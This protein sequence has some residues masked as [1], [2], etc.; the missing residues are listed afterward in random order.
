M[1]GTTV[2]LAVVVACACGPTAVLG[3]YRPVVLMHGLDASASAMSR[4]LQWVE[5][6]FPGIHV[7]NVEVGNGKTDS[8]FM[9]IEKQ[10]EAFAAAVRADPALANGFNLICHSQGGMLGR[11]YIA[12][13]NTPPVHNFITWSSPH[14]GVYGVPDFNAICPDK[15]CPWLNELFSELME[16]GGAILQDH[17]AFAAYWRDPMNYTSWLKYNK[18]LADI[19]NLRLIKNSTY[20]ANMASLNAFLMMYTTKDGIVVPKDS[21]WFDFFA[22]GSDKVIVPLR[23][24]EGYLGDWIGLKTLDKSGR[25]ILNKCNCTHQDYP[26][27]D[28]KW[29]YDA[30]TKPLLNNTL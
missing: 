28:C 1:R 6:D 13:F 15:D 25:L 7:N 22:E 3:T 2:A 14:A 24:T 12:K 17:I 27:P 21:P 20:K 8:W 29:A 26:R 30:Y 5:A 11:A 18:F 23:E 19:N 10:V 9:P 4:V 16:G